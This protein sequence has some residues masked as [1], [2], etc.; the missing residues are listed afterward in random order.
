MLNN[1]IFRCGPSRERQS[2]DRI[3][4]VRT[5]S[6]NRIHIHTATEDLHAAPNDRIAFAG[7]EFFCI[8]VGLRCCRDNRYLNLIRTV[9]TVNGHSV[10]IVYTVGRDVLFVPVKYCTLRQIL[11]LL[12]IE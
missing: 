6:R 12:A 7:G 11:V 3:Y 10:I 4:L 2:E 9:A 8:L 5:R 1:R